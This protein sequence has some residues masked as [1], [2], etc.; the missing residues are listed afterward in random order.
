MHW[1]KK[2]AYGV[3]GVIG[4]VVTTWLAGLLNQ[5][6][7]SPERTVLA[8]TNAV[9]RTDSVWG[10]GFRVVLCWLEEDFHG[11]NTK[12]VER[13]FT[14]VFGI[15]IERSAI[16]VKGTGAGLDW[17][18]DMRRQ[19]REILEAWQADLVI[20]GL[21]KEAAL[22]L[23]FVPREGDDTLDKPETH[24]LL[25]H[26]T[27]KPDFHDSLHS[28]I[29][30]LSLAAA[31][32]VASNDQQR[33]EV[34]IM[35]LE[36]HANKIQ[37]MINSGS[38]NKDRNLADLHR[39]LGVTLRELGQR[40]G[41]AERLKAAV[42]ALDASL[43]AYSAQQNKNAWRNTNNDLGVTLIKLG[44][45][46]GDT[47]SLYQAVDAFEASIRE[48]S[49]E[50]RRKMAMFQ[51]NLGYARARIGER[52]CDENALNDAI[53]AFEKSLKERIPEEDPLE[54]AA[55]K[56]N[57]GTAL[58][59]LGQQ[60]REP[61]RVEEA[62]A[63]FKEVLDAIDREQMP[64]GWAATNNN[65]GN[66]FLT[67]GEM[68]KNG[69]YVEKAIDAFRDA[70]KERVLKRVPLQWAETRNNLGSARLT[71]GRMNNQ[72]GELD[73]G[74]AAF[75]DALKERVRAH[76]P[77]QW[78]DTRYNL[79]FANMIRDQRQRKPNYLEEF[80]AAL[81]D[82]L[83]E[84]SREKTPLHW[85]VVTN[86]LGVALLH[87]GQEGRQAGHLERA[88]VVF[89]EVSRVES[90]CKA[91]L[92]EKANAKGSLALARKVWEDAN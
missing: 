9:K 65:L 12:I 14:T 8:A 30:V 1:W 69:A 75:Q 74:I 5:F 16:V 20:V 64:L 85:A 92:W 71:L 84:Y 40:E 60:S 86:N 70:L 56:S 89:E 27:L 61:K 53:A 59:T 82:V 34:L 38:S 22:G 42:E 39:A 19:A 68:K 80:V 21:A 10:D 32:S 72:E 54:W 46:E 28:Q 31:L 2:I 66:A 90:M 26:S 25:E 37:L 77:L 29:S 24:Y 35:E 73:A 17:Q 67:L 81:D 79:A 13:A 63:V 6:V 7:P 76:V 41:N 43:T 51:H 49:K 47:K 50:D 58:M 33:N 62:E 18:V 48:L 83:N 23:W 52:R 88:I 44:E 36:K 4:F 87:L 57:L 15:D 11:N 55:T 91:V 45:Y 78:A 3:L